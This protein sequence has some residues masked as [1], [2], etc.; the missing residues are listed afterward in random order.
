MCVRITSIQAQ[1]KNSDRVSVFIDDRFWT[2]MSQNLLIETGL[3]PGMEMTEDLVKDLEL[4]VVEDEAMGYALRRISRVMTSEKTLRGKLVE[5]GYGGDIQQKVVDELERLALLDDEAM[6]EMICEDALDRNRGLNW[7]RKKLADK[8]VAIDQDLLEAR[9]PEETENTRALAC[10][11]SITKERLDAR[12]ARRRLNTL[13]SRGFSYPAAASAIEARTITEEEEAELHGADEARELI[14]RK[15]GQI[16]SYQ[17]RKKAW[18]FLRRRG[19]V[20][21][22]IEEALG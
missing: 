13:I 5:R 4:K 12:Q 1:K 10:L 16:D 3:A 2:G 6:A 8:G 15:Y 22:I 11:E 18:D 19:F 20:S 17:T 9:F 21:S 7:T 14:T